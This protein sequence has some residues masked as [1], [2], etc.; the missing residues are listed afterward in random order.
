ML[1]SDTEI[2]PWLSSETLQKTSVFGRWISKIS[3]TYFTS[4]IKGITLRITYLN[5]I[6][7]TSIAPKAITS[8]T[9]YTTILE[10]P[11]T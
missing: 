9:Y 7:S 11:C 2:K 8:V 5:A 6:Y 3:D 10:I 1:D 4:V